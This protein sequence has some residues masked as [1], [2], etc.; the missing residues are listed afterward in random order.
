MNEKTIEQLNKDFSIDGQ[1]QVVQ[2][3]GGFPFVEIDNGEGFALISIYAGQLLS[4][5]PASETE[6]LM[7]LSRRAHYEDGKAIK[8]GIPIC[9]PWFGPDPEQQGRQAHGFA[10]S[11]YWK[12]LAT[13]A[14]P[15]GSTKVT[16]G[17]S[18][19]EQSR[20]IWP[21]KFELWLEI[22][23]GATLTVSLTTH[24]KSHHEFVMTQ[25]FHTYFSVAD[26]SRVSVLGL[27]GVEYQDAADEWTQKEQVGALTVDGEVNRVYWGADEDIVLV[28]DVRGRHIRIVATNSNTAIVWNPWSKVAASMDDLEDND[29][30]RFICLETT[31]AYV[32]VVE[33]GP[34]ETYCLKT[35]YS[36]GRE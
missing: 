2:G 6:D 22:E 5:R 24:N 21:N 32:D 19:D 35:E 30:Q 8:G 23:V 12:L 9:W 15:E 3:D 28:D 34:D 13:E 26:I 20:S 16:L 25:G 36:V 11:C 10:R 4:Y 33:I 1:L 29:Y 7:F 17:L 14:T 31:N 27:E 18:D